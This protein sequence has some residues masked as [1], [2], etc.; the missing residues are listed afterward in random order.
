MHNI[1]DLRTNLDNF[2]KSISGRNTEIDFE[3]IINLDKEN[4]FLIQEKEK[5]EM[6]KKKFQNQKTN[7]YLKNQKKFL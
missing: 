7:L 5:F 4:R 3:N 1:K 2:K 6:E